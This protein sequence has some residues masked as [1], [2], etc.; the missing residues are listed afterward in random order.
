MRLKLFLE[1]NNKVLLEKIYYNLSKI[2]L[3][4]SILKHIS[5]FYRFQLAL[6]CHNVSGTI[7]VKKAAGSSHASSF[8]LLFQQQTTDV[9]SVK[10]K[11]YIIVL[12]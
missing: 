12:T 6:R 11:R 4:L 2:F 7:T 10:K 8:S 3:I 9:L 1:Y 5:N